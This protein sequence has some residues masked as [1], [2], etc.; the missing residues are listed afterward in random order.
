MTTPLAIKVALGEAGDVVDDR[1]RSLSPAA[2]FS[3]ELHAAAIERWFGRAGELLAGELLGRR[4]EGERL[5]TPLI[6]D[7]DILAPLLV[8]LVDDHLRRTRQMAP[9]ARIR[10]AERAARVVVLR[11]GFGETYAQIASRSEVAASLRSVKAAY[12]LLVDA[13]LAAWRQQRLPPPI[14]PVALS[15]PRSR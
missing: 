7:F 5:R 6:E 12:A 8:G 3:W 11:L 2:A 14:V 15:A 1:P 13:Y 9:V 10:V 4:G